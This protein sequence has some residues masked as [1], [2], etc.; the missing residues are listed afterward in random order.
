MLG[1]YR[2]WSCAPG[3]ACPAGFDSAQHGEANLQLPQHSGRWQSR[4]MGAKR[5]RTAVH[6]PRD[7]SF[8]LAW[9]SVMGFAEFHGAREV[10][11][12]FVVFPWDS[13]PVATA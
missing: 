12:S 4:R 9:R 10:Q 2:S 8:S 1:Q 6:N 7:L 11:W 13:K 3:L 5:F